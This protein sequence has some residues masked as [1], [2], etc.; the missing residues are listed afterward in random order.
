MTMKNIFQTLFLI[1]IIALWS[2][3]RAYEVVIHIDVEHKSDNTS[4]N[5][6]TGNAYS[7]IG[8]LKTEIPLTSLN[9]R[10]PSS[11]NESAEEWAHDWLGENLEELIQSTGLAPEL[12]EVELD[13]KK[14]KLRCKRRGT[15]ECRGELSLELSVRRL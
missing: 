13:L 4:S 2:Q 8:D 3:A 10:P 5:L 6:T 11:S 7:M 14:H 9:I 15:Q 1:G 12:V